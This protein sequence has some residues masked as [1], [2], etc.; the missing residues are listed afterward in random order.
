MNPQH[1]DD[2]TGTGN[3]L[4]FSQPAVIKMTLDSL[5]VLDRGDGRRRLPL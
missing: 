2:V 1:Y 5:Q 4:D 3:S